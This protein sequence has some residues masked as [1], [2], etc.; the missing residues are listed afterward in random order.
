MLLGNCIISKDICSI[1]IILIT[2]IWREKS[3]KT[4]KNTRL[5]GLERLMVNTLSTNNAFV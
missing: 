2:S 3:G 5:T 4:N 1:I